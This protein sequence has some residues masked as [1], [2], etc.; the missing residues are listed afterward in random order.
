MNIALLFVFYCHFSHLKA[1]YQLAGKSE[2]E[3]SWSR[4]DWPPIIIIF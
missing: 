2:V 4:A 1:F 3:P